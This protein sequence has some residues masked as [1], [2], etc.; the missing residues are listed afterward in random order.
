MSG[1]FG[2]LEG[3]A[4][5]NSLESDPGKANFTYFPICIHKLPIVHVFI[6]LNFMKKACSRF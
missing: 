4:K 5:W 6:D 2:N 1:L 3:K